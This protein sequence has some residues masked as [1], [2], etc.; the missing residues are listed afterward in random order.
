VTTADAL[1]TR[2]LFNDERGTHAN[3]PML[4][5]VTDFERP[6]ISRTDQSI[7]S[8]P[9]SRRERTLRVTAALLTRREL[10]RISRS[11]KRPKH[12]SAGWGFIAPFLVIFLFVL[13]APIVYAIYLS[14]FQDRLVGGNSFVGFANFAQVLG[15]SQFYAGLGRV[16]LFLVV[17]VPIMTLAATVAALAIDSARL[18]FPSFFRIFFFLPYAIPSV[19]AALMWGF[20]Y[21]QNFGLVGSLN[22]FFHGSIPDVL[23]GNYILAAIGNIST[24]E[25]VGYNMLVLY[26]AL[27]IIPKDLYEAAAIDG[28]SELQIIWR[29]K[30]PAMRG[31]FVVS[32]VFSVIGSLQL[33]AEPSVLRTLAPNSIG[34]DFTPNLY[35]YSLAFAGNEYNYSA[36]VAIV[37]GL[38]TMAAAYI[39]QRVGTR[40]DASL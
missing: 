9:L 15:D 18:L 33:F 7:R 10:A 36:A 32:I 34:S 8:A 27:K 20:I 31:A 26:G 11:G 5:E 2:A 12:E 39:V 19:V 28:A 17:Q 25:F 30:L 4:G 22:T 24:W 3:R 6:S 13:I 29:I 38:I 35:A 23:S 16:S 37:M 21:G 40:R 14:L 1:I